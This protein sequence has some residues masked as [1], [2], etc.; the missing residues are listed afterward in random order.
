MKNIV[1]NETVVQLRKICRIIA[2]V[3]AQQ[4]PKL[5]HYGHESIFFQN[6]G[7]TTGLINNNK[8]IKIDLFN[9]LLLY[10]DNEYTQTIDLTDG[11]IYLNLRQLFSHSLEMLQIDNLEI[12]KLEDLKDYFDFISKA[13]LSLEIFRSKLNGN[14][15]LVHL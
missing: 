10:Y 4:I 9:G 14:F 12:L 13:N 3:K 15:T 8:E 7:I 11:N 2:N 6:S 5:P 1:I